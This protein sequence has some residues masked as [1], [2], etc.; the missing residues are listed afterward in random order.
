MLDVSLIFQPE[1]QQY[2][3]CNAVA[4]FFNLTAM[5]NPTT[6]M[7]ASLGTV[8]FLAVA[9]LLLVQ[10]VLW[11]ITLSG[12]AKK[13]ALMITVL[14]MARITKLLTVPL[15]QVLFFGWKCTENCTNSQP[16]F[17]AVG[18]VIYLLQVSVQ[19]LY[20]KF[21]FNPLRENNSYYRYGSDYQ[22]YSYLLKAIRTAVVCF[23]GV[24][25]WVL[26]LGFVGPFVISCKGCTN[27]LVKS[28]CPLSERAVAVTSAVVLLQYF[29]MPLNSTF[30][31]W[32]VLLVGLLS[33]SVYF[34]I[35]AYV[36]TSINF[37]RCCRSVTEE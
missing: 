20:A 25:V 37:F 9:G 24:S 29:M 35:K 3:N 27:S 22:L 14:Q 6:Y 21:Y 18:P 31:T 19:F 30:Y 36:S 2:W 17:R 8:L 5:I 16:M 28:I 1:L 15:G 13:K 33:I 10:A 12:I 23:S 32:A 4:G 26:L 11:G 7:T 34:T